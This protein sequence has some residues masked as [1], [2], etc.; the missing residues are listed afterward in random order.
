MSNLDNVLTTKQ[1]ADRFGVAPKT[2]HRW[3]ERGLLPEAGKLDGLRGARLFFRSD[4]D[5]LAVE[6]TKVS[7]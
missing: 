3:V 6:R 4:V 2:V 7:A 1:V 5:A